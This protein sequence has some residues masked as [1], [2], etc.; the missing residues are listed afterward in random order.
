MTFAFIGFGEVSY[1][2]SKGFRQ[3][4]EDKTPFFA[5]DVALGGGKAIER[6]IRDRAAEV[7]AVLADS[8]EAAVRDADV[9]FCA[10][11]GAYALE[12]GAAAREF[13][14]SGAVYIDLTT[15][16][17]SHKRSL[18]QDYAEKNLDFVDA[19][20]LG[21]LPLYLHKVPM[22]ISGSGAA[23]A[24]QIMK[25][26]NMNAALVAGGAGEASKIKLTRSV[27]MKGLQA[28][29]VETLLFARK[30]GVEEIVLESISETMS[31]SSFKDTATRLVAA[32]LIHAERR[33]H[34]VSDSILVMKEIGVS[35]IVAAAVQQRLLASAALGYREEL[36]GDAPKSLAE[37]YPLWEK[38][39]Y[40]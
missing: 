10:V 2:I 27:F 4:F 19:A 1:S 37:T 26:R 7:G 40:V 8:L 16:R 3:D 23:K 15:A 21:P 11:Q 12:V 33:A 24:L 30:A 22:L 5:Y 32:D 34:E 25:D 9:V 38:K 36:G 29:L 31:K 14:K 18:E 28:L 35:P 17:P 39:Q 20:M 13:L 6:T